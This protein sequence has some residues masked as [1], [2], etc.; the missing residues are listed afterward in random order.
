M[1]FSSANKAKVF[2]LVWVTSYFL[3][4][5]QIINSSILFI[6]QMIKTNAT[7][8]KTIAKIRDSMSGFD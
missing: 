7:I 6:Y 1:S 4:K 3:F 8:T 5:M 2:R